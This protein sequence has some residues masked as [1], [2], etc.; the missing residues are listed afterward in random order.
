M[1]QCLFCLKDYADLTEEHVFPA[2]LGGVLVVERSVCATC[3]HGFS[4]FEQPLAME[5]APLRSLLKI[6]DR[7]GKV[8]EAAATVKTKEEEYAAKVLADGTVRL[9][10]IVTE[11][12]GSGGR[13]EFIHRFTTA[14]QKA[15]LE[16]EAQ[17]RGHELIEMGRGEPQEAEV[18]VGGEFNLVDASEGLRTVSKIAYVGLA[19]K[20]GARTAASD[21][22]KEVRAYIATG[23]GPC[24][25]RLFVNPKFSGAVQ[26]GPHQH[27]IILAGRRD[28]KRVDAI[29]R[30]FGE[31]NYFVTLSDHYE[32]VD[33]GYTLLYDACRG[34]ADGI[35]VSDLQFEFLATLDV[36]TSPETTWDDLAAS[37]QFFCNFLQ[38]AVTRK[39]E[40]AQADL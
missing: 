7:Y 26:Q 32:G 17:K 19:F 16:E 15:E 6:P 11:V 18:H 10:R 37:S 25:T 38:E 27:A 13:R 8:P 34:Q 4:K 28:M 33:F 1:S 14:K 9:K 5:L 39:I 3:N 30:L 21:A 22:F 31:L 2:A 23:A 35:L 29:V 24:P 20:A 12:T 40:R 36:A